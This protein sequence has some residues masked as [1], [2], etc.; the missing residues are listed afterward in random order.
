MEM[1]AQPTGNSVVCKSPSGGQKEIDDFD[2]DQRE[3]N[4]VTGG[5]LISV[6]GD[7]IGCMKWS[8]L[9]NLMKKLGEKQVIVYFIDSIDCILKKTRPGSIPDRSGITSHS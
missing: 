6:T 7:D 4:S 1:V 8:D 5:C 2:G 9:C 3:W